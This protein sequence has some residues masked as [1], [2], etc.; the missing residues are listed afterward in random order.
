MCHERG[1]LKNG[2]RTLFLSLFAAIML[3]YIWSMTHTYNQLLSIIM[4]PC[5]FVGILLLNDFVKS[6][7]W[8]NKALSFCGDI[9]FSIYL[10][11]ILIIRI[12][13]NEAGVDNVYVVAVLSLVLTML[14]SAAIYLL[15][16][17]RFINYAKQLIKQRKI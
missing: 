12:V 8:W 6:D 5:V 11:H 13:V 14:A 16:E 15:V 4:S 7:S 2:K 3:A 10:V 17:K 9:S 1:W